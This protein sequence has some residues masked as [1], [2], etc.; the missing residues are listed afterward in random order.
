MNST[1][2]AG[3]PQGVGELAALRDGYEAVG[4]A[5]GDVERGSAVVH[6]G[7]R[8]GAAGQVG[9]LGQRGADELRLARVRGVGAGDRV[10]PGLGGHR[11][12]VRG[13]VPVDDAR[14]AGVGEPEHRGEVGARR[15]AP[16]DDPVG[17]DTE[18]VGAGA[19]PA[20]RGL[21][22]VELGGE[23]RLA[24]QAVVDRRDGEAGGDEP[25]ERVG[26]PV[27]QGRAEH[28]AVPSR[29]PPPCTNTITGAGPSAGV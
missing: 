29:K 3:L 5:V 8:A 18:L 26:A 4:V 19:Q 27:A 25:G 7:H 10:R 20:D 21:D 1:S 16:R 15:L 9:C 11:R 14:D 17:V 28:R 22:V 2:D 24:G 23:D 13:A 6:V 12:Q